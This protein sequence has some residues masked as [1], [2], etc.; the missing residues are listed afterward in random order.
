MKELLARLRLRYRYPGIV[1]RAMV[2]TDFKVRYQA[3][4]LGYLWTLLKPLA[5]F[6]ILYLVFVRLLKIGAGIP[7]YAI[8]LL[9]GIVIWMFFVEATMTGLASL[10]GRADL[11]RKISFPRYVV[12]VSVGAS[13]MINFGLNMVVIALFLVLARVHVGVDILWAPLL[14][15]ELVALSVSLAFILSAMYVRFR[16]MTYIWEVVMQAGF[17]AVPIIYPLNM[18]PPRYAKL[19]LLNPM[20]QII[21]DARFVLVTDQTKTMTQY[22]GTPWV[23]VIPVGITIALVIG[24]V[25]FFRRRSPTFAE[26][27]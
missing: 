25:V 2:G 1:L 12:P 16:D 22:F 20:A 21:Q 11:L 19:L 14:F 6:S 9:L 23:R 18:V 13:A 5:I 3:S 10:V 8:Y 24:S 15:V 7:H 26:E 17:Y 27:A 4:L